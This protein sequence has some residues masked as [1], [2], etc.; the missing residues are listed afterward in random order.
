MRF[1]GAVEA[2]K[3]DAPFLADCTQC[4]ATGMVVIGSDT[5]LGGFVTC[6]EG[7]CPRCKGAGELLWVERVDGELVSSPVVRR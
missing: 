6:M 2:S 3:P 4:F 1:F 7:I 5:S